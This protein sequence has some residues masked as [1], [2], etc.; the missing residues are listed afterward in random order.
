MYRAHQ[1]E[2]RETSS[3]VDSFPSGLEDEPCEACYTV[4]SNISYC[5]ICDIFFCSPCWDAQ[6]QHNQQR[7]QRNRDRDPNRLPHEKTDTRLAKKIRDALAPSDDEVTLQQ[8]Y[9]SDVQ[10]AWFGIDRPDGDL[11][12]FKDY[13]RYNYLLSATADEDFGH[14]QASRDDRTP[15]LVSF[16]GQSGAGKSTLIKLLIDL[17]V[18]Q[19]QSFSTPVVGRPGSTDPT[20]EDVH[21]Y[22]D[23]VTGASKAPLF[24]A[25][26]EGLLG[27]E[28]EPISTKLKRSFHKA[29][30]SI[31]SSPAISE[32][33]LTW[34][35]SPG[36]RSRQYA[37]MNLYP[38]LLYTFSDV[39]V[40]VLKNPRVIENVFEQLL[41][42]A[43]A[44]LEM[45]S[46]QPV[47]PHVIIA[48][49]ASP[50]EI[51]ESQWDPERA[52]SSIF[53]SVSQTTFQNPIFQKHARFWRERERPIA[54]VHQLVMSYYSSDMIVRIPQ[55]GRPHR[56]EEQINK[57][58]THISR[59]CEASRDRK[60]ALRMLLDA[61]E[62]QS[63]LQYAFDHFALS[64]DHPFDFV[65][66][67]FS[68]SPIPLDFGGNILKL[69][70]NLMRVWE[71]K[72][73]TQI[74]FQ[75][76]SYM[77]A[78]CIML[79]TARQAIKGTACDIFPEYLSHL[80]AAL[81]NFC[82]MYWPCEYVHIGS[83]A[84][85]VN[86]RSGHGKKGHQN[87]SGKVIADGLYQSRWTFETLQNEFT[88][89]SYFR[90]EELL[91]LLQQKQRLG[92][93]NKHIAAEIHRDDVM[94]YFYNHVSGK[95]KLHEYNSHT[96]C[97]CCLS[98][99]PEHALPCGHVLCTPC[100]ETYG[101]K[102]SKTEVDMQ[103]CPL[104][105]QAARS[106][107]S[108]KIHFKPEFAGVRVLSLDGGGIRGIIELE[109]LRSIENVWN[110]MNRRLRIQ[111]FFDLITGTSTGGLIALGM[112]VRNWP[113]ENCIS[114]FKE[115]C[116]K[117]FTR[118]V[119]GNIPLIGW[120]V[121]SY[122]HSMYETT[123]LHEALQTAFPE[124]Q[125][126]FGGERYNQ[127]E[128]SSVKVAVTTTI[129]SKSPMVLANYNRRCDDKCKLCYARATSAAPR[130]FKP[131]HHQTTKQ[132]YMDGALYN[133][134]PI[135]IADTEWK[136]I[137]SASPCDHPDLML[138]L[139]TGYRSEQPAIP[140]RNTSM[141]RGLFKNG[142]MM[143]RI[144]TDH[145]QDALNCEKI[146]HDYIR[147][148]PDQMTL[149]R[150]IRYNPKINDLP[151]LDDVH[152]IGRLQKEVREQL[153]TDS[154][155]IGRIAMQLVATTFYFETERLL[156]Q[157]HNNAIATGRIY[158]RFGEGSVEMK[159]LG[160][161]L[162][163]KGYHDKNPSFQVCERYS[164]RTNQTRD[165]TPDIVSN[166]VACGRFHFRRMEIPLQNKL[167]EVEIWLDLNGDH[168][169]LISA[170]PRRLSEDS[171]ERISEYFPRTINAVL[172][173]NRNTPATFN[174]QSEMGWWFNPSAKRFLVSPGS[175]KCPTPTDLVEL[176]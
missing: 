109:I 112:V 30:Q 75:E 44:A 34:A 83:G 163:D 149:S 49:N 78:S 10:T 146:W 7:R 26:C 152:A 128:T 8:L 121:N 59:D 145:I 95:G 166:M 64:L 61:E 99:P 127:S 148:L 36:L 46:N 91:E 132:I 71:N 104:E 67:S 80:Y 157:P 167:Y 69:A 63:Y 173:S 114:N 138:S 155:L 100:V 124:N 141:K 154:I 77:V 25:D 105:N 48:L 137:W 170:F 85:C 13:G 147:P 53:D 96:V 9:E 115:L 159:E 72:A 11:P 79:D 153:N 23:P 76:L 28:R 142:K 126:L 97:F 12:I 82:E 90:L 135:R 38:R 50:N 17:H 136:L 98:K 29:A 58:Y 35:D 47:L 19:D 172:S 176:F 165:I 174:Q 139:G 81:E 87:A 133:N 122:N 175:I 130:Y 169:H 106:F 161:L 32:R 65:Q 1:S 4:K 60:A 102:R 131:F 3:R 111:N 54:T 51:E 101:H 103:G 125:Y 22:A 55:N 164:G 120:F 37:V 92:V 70:I 24:F 52:T 158:C 42:W 156:Q 88:C 93:L 66:A 151:E 20:S 168:R 45:S 119:G 108:W 18:R 123:P 21:L 134:N 27:G 68:N 5:N 40:F 118:R 31:T 33:E 39:I 84:R 160:K 89:N 15:S 43:A 110:G 94:A 14:S 143:F 150:F 6:V 56:I 57:L 86:V 74:I 144:A 140:E 113:V 162:R 129:A 171:N 16:V 62:L 73:D 117:A 2:S 41:E 116:G 107:Q